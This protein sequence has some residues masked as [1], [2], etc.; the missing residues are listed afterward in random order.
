M[1]FIWIS[2][3]KKQWNE[4]YNIREARMRPLS[5]G[6]RASVKKGKPERVTKTALD[7]CGL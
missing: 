4:F 6:V 7:C 1:A 3:L 2:G 5:I